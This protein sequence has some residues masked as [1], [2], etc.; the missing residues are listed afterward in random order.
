MNKINIA[1]IMRAGN[2][3]TPRADSKGNALINCPFHDDKKASCSVNYESGVYNCFGCGAHGGTKA[4]A[5]ALGIDTKTLRGTLGG[6]PAKASSKP[7]PAMPPKPPPRLIRLDEGI[8]KK[9]RRAKAVWIYNNQK[10]IGYAAVVRFEGKEGKEIRPLINTADGYKWQAPPVRLLY[11]IDK[12]LANPAAALFFCEGEQAADACQKIIGDRGIATTWIGGAQGLGKTGGIAD[13]CAGRK[14]YLWADNDDP[15]IAV[16]QR[17][18][19]LATGAREIV[20]VAIPQ[21]AV[22]GYDAADALADGKKAGDIKT[23]KFA[24]SIVI[25]DNVAPPDDETQQEE[26]NNFTPIPMG[27]DDGFF[28]VWSRASCLL[29]RMKKGSAAMRDSLLA[30]APASFYAGNFPHKALDFDANHAVDWLMSSCRARGFFAPTMVRGRGVARDGGGI[31]ANLG[32]RLVI[33]K[34]NKRQVINIGNQRDF[35]NVYKV[36]KPLEYKG[37]KMLAASDVAQL[38]AGLDRLSWAHKDSPKILTGW[39]VAALVGGALR[40]RPHCWIS[41]ASRSGKT[42][43]MDNVIRPILGGF[44]IFATAKT[45]EAGV[46]G[47]LNSE[48]IPVVFDE[49]ESENKIEK[50]RLQGVIDLARQASSDDGARIIK[51][52]MGGEGTNVHYCRSCFLFAS[53]NYGLDAPADRNRFVHLRAKHGKKAEAE[54]QQIAK[55]IT[56][57]T[58]NGDWVDAFRARAIAATPKIYAVAEQC[59]QRISAIVGDRRIGDTMGGVLAGYMVATGGTDINAL[60]DSIDLSPDGVFEAVEA[61]DVGII[62]TLFGKLLPRG[63]ATLWQLIKR[64]RQAARAGAISES[65]ERNNNIAASTLAAYGVRVDGDDIYIGDN[66]NIRDSIFADT[67]WGGAWFSTIRQNNHINSGGGA[68]R[69][70]GDHG[71][72]RKWVSISFTLLADIFDGNDNDD[73]GDGG[74]F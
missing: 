25:P 50:A 5:D 70:V 67:R 60:I 57:L 18:A 1:D 12:A 35:D 38:T 2:L 51:G 24:P 4:F 30:I 15:G 65:E 59:A 19:A 16:M 53:V 61:D 26:A 22:K 17:I 27:Y 8:S 68:R 72:T 21:G 36:G 10:G 47:E 66:V 32:D 54:F 39:L 37:K 48:S 33:I 58:S 6:A 42:W 20:W 31:V 52:V 43:L 69:K 46:R 55:S 34:D 23:Q 7:K 3:P 74:D 13:I 62:R 44:C 29:H 49:A 73:K 41:G 45:T 63:D 64:H 9:T 14:I 28:Y 56:T 71:I 40:W 11:Q